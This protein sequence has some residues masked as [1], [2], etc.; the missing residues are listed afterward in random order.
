LQAYM[1]FLSAL[2]DR[3][4]QPTIGIHD[5]LSEVMQS[6]CGIYRQRLRS[7]GEHLLGTI[8][9]FPPR[10]DLIGRLLGL[11]FDF[12][13]EN[14]IF[15]GNLLTLSEI[16]SSTVVCNTV[17]SNV[18]SSLDRSSLAISIGLL[19]VR[20]QKWITTDPPPPP[21]P[22]PPPA[23]SQRTTNGGTRRV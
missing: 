18:V 13:Y 14:S 5:N 17:L 22:P 23:M 3:L 21:P 12:W 6:S 9:Y 15:S 2:L 4:R 8:K 7:V 19:K 1:Q 16:V 20:R 11:A 10:S